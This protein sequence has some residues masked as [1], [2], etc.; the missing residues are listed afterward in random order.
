M[1]YMRWRKNFKFR[2]GYQRLKRREGFMKG[3]EA[4]GKGRIS[5]NGAGG[6]SKTVFLPV[7]WVRTSIFFLS[8]TEQNVFHVATCSTASWNFWFMHKMY[9]ILR[10]LVKEFESHCL[11]LWEIKSEIVYLAGK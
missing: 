6:P 4:C 2:E 5:R 1:S 10:V 7:Q 3:H 9:F 11:V 8:E